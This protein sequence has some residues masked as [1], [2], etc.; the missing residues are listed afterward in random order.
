MNRIG[1]VDWA[2]AILIY[3]MAVGHCGV[4]EN[5]FIF[6]YSFHMPAFFIISG[7][8]YKEHNWLSTTQKFVI[9]ILFFSFINCA[10]FIA[11]EVLHDTFYPYSFMHKAI[12]PY[13][14]SLTDTTTYVLLFP[15][16]WFI[17]VLYICRLLLGDLR[18][19]SPIKK[20]APYIILTISI[21]M[22]VEPHLN[23]SN[24]IKS[25]HLY[26]VIPCFP[27]ILIGYILK[28][29][30]TIVKL[31][32]SVLIVLFCIFPALIK[33]NG[34]CDIY[35]HT[36]GQ[37]YLFFLL[38]A[39]IGSVILFNLCIYLPK[40]RLSTI[41]SCGTFLILATHLILRN[42]INEYVSYIGI[43]LTHNYIYPWCLVI[44]LFIVYYYPILLLLRTFPIL[45]GKKK[46]T[47]F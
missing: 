9:P 19:F 47:I 41:Y 17:F 4:N 29:Y 28:K 6:I 32:K 11:I 34:H 45:L 27:F 42:K 43:N 21:Y 38:N 33:L 16:F 25:M 2:K 3:L 35:Q 15:G 40:L 23:I 13:L 8:L 12:L 39:V 24:Q 20:Y 44:I 18:I 1:W 26:K 36:F 22:W 30:P 37:Q 7:F 5:S 46:I 31:P 10:Y 14:T